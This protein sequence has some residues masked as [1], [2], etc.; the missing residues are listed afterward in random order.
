MRLRVDSEHELLQTDNVVDSLKNINEFTD[1]DNVLSTEVLVWHEGKDT[2]WYG[3][4]A[5][6]YQDIVTL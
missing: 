6:Q 2:L 1:K 3:M 4:I 5:A